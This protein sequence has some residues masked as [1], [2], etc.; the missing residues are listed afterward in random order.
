M[1]TLQVGLSSLA[2]FRSLFSLLPREGLFGW[3]KSASDGAQSYINI[4]TGGVSSDA[5][6][7][8][9]FRLRLQ[10][11]PQK[12]RKTGGAAYAFGAVLFVG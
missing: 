12:R 4:L 1:V 8:P 10:L 7:S 5:S 2:G 11:D 3:V 9:V 6:N